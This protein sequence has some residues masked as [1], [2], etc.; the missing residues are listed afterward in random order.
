MSRTLRTL[1]GLLVLGVATAQAAFPPYV[2]R[3]LKYPAY[4]VWD[5]RLPLIW[6]GWKA[7]FVENGL[8]GGNTPGQTTK[9]YISEGQSYGMLLAVWMGDQAAFNT[10]WDAT[11]T[12][13]WNKGSGK[14]YPWNITTFDANYA[15]DADIDIAGA[16]IFASALVDS[17][18]WSNYKS[19]GYKA[20]AKIVLQSVMDNFIDKGSNYRINSWPGAGDGIRNPSYHMPNWYPIFKEFAAENGMAAF[21][22]DKAAS[23]AFDLIEAQ[24]SSKLGMARNFSNG[25]GGSPGGGTSSPNNYDMGFDAIR[26]PFRMALAAQWYPKKF[27]RAVAW[28]KSVWDA[29]FVDPG[30]P[31]LYTLSNPPQL[32]GWADFKYEKLMTRAMWGSIA[33]AVKDSSDAS[34]LAYTRILQDLSASVKSG[35]NHLVG[36]GDT[37]LATS[38]QRNYFAQSLGLLGALATAGRAWNVWDDMKHAW[39][40]PDTSVKITSA[41]KATPSTITAVT[42]GAAVDTPSNV[43]RI[44]A[45][46]SRSVPWTL[47]IFIPGTTASLDTA[48]TSTS[49][50]YKWNSTRKNRTGAA[51]TPGIVQVR[52]VFNGVD[53]VSNSNN[54]TTITLSPSSGIA[55]RPLRGVGNAGWV[56]GGLRLQDNFWQAGDQV[57]VQVRDINGRALGATLSSSFHQDPSGLVLGLPTSH[58][59]SVRILEVTSATSLE[60]RQYLISPNP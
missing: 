25:S 40:V 11:E 15:G 36:T 44:T 16:L 56:A 37:T 4:P 20:K 47:K 34:G 28:G 12:Q 39:V 9:S 43:T 13:F 18:K 1:I 41:L 3:Q 17:G 50:S 21:D 38:Y 58:S 5:S 7:R 10:I 24:P 45:T 8:V 23:G 42:T 31:G 29:G 2:E 6:E 60:T 57:N 52:L 59:M 19:G 14:Y 46:L 22:W 32:Y 51:F 27:P 53:S 55:K 35:V 54:K 26:V 30:M 33:A 49:I 48:G